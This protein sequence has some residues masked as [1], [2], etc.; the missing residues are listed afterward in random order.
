MKSI[1]ARL[2]V[3]LIILVALISLIAAAVTYRRVSNETS[4][5]FDYQLRQMALSLRGQISLAPRI[6]VP[7]DQGDSDFVVQIWDVFGAR[8]Y[9]SRPGLPMINQTVLGYADLSLR[10]EAW[11]AYGLQTADGVIQIAQPVRVRENLARAAAERVVIPLILLLPVMIGSVAWIVSRGLLPLRF[12][13]TE[14]QRRD[15]SSLTPL[16]TRNLPRE[17]E[18]LVGELNRLLERLQRAF[19][20]QRAFISDAAHELRSPLTALRLQ[21]QLLDRAP[22]EAA[23]VE[24]RS[25]LGTAVERAIHLVEQLL[26]LARSEPQGAAVNFET[27][28]LSAAAAEGIRDTHDL[29]MARNIDL[30]LD[31]AP[32]VH[33]QGDPEALR[34]LVRNLVDNAARY[35]PVGGAVQVRTGKLPHEAVLEV[36]DNGPGIAPA[37]RERVFDRFYRRAAAQESGTGLGLAIVKAIAERHGARIVL[38]EAPG[39]G[40]RVVVSFPRAS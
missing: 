2:L 24:A 26:T 38:Q 7:P 20:A 33:I 5:L 21:L 35:T 19:S 25:R 30:G 12:V 9:V 1:R 17:I 22:D 10:G 32:H 28:D 40:L 29:A 11:R 31:A 36:S 8:T 39:G 34:A 14:V 6:E 15:V 27:V 18:P 13:T 37:D 23:G 16:R 3:A 4:T